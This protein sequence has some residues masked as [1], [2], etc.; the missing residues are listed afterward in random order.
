[1][2]SPKPLSILRKVAPVLLL[3]AASLL[4]A[5]SARAECLQ[6]LR[7]DFSASSTFASM[8]NHCSMRIGYTYCVMDER[9]T[10]S[11]T[12]QKFGSGFVSPGG[13]DTIVVMTTQGD[14]LPGAAVLWAACENDIPGNYVLPASPRAQGTRIFATCPRK[15]DDA[16]NGGKKPG[17]SAGNDNPFATG[18]GQDDNPFTASK[19]K[20][21]GDNPF[22]SDGSGRSSAPRTPQGTAAKAA[23]PGHPPAKTSIPASGSYMGTFIMTHSH[24]EPRT[25]NDGDMQ[26]Q[27]TFSLNIDN[28]SGT[29]TGSAQISNPTNPYDMSGNGPCPTG[30]QHYFWRDTALGG[31]VTTAPDGRG[32]FSQTINGSLQGSVPATTDACIAAAVTTTQI[33][34]C[35]NGAAPPPE[36]RKTFS[37]NGCSW[38]GTFTFT[39]PSSFQGSGNLSCDQFG[40]GNNVISGSWSTN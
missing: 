14:A 1:M 18:N 7:S 33:S 30:P 36:G 32:G 9:S 20:T 38:T 11:C 24:A 34:A 28:T 3:A 27:G 35:G 8:V 12:D 26:C 22:L 13:K 39:P 17:E 25:G 40:W 37:S 4:F 19:K 10:F 5:P 23:S 31:T 2:L 29:V 21:D 15:K 6:V 16:N